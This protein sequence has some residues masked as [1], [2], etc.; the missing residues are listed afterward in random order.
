MGRRC[1]AS[2]GVQSLKA[3]LTGQGALLPV[4]APSCPLREHRESKSAPK[5]GRVQVPHLELN[6]DN[7]FKRNYSW[8]FLNV[9][10]FCD[11]N[12]QIPNFEK[13]PNYSS[14]LRQCEPKKELP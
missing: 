7:L 10:I 4:N 9:I 14:L 5:N 6:K 3:E 12:R 2:P 1:Q 13:C 8:I 11:Q